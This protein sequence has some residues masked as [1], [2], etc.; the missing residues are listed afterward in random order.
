MKTSNPVIHEVFPTPLLIFY[1]EPPYEMERYALL[2]EQIANTNPHPQSTRNCTQ[3]YDN[4]DELPEFKPLVD[5]IF[6]EFGLILNTFEYIRTGH[7]VNG[8][9]GNVAKND[10]VHLTHPHPNNVFSG[11]IYLRVPEGSGDTVFADPRPGA[12]VIKPDSAVTKITN[13]KI[14]VAADVGKVVVFPSWLHHGVL[15]SNFKNSDD[16]RITLAFNI[17]LEGKISGQHTAKLTMKNT[18]QIAGLPPLK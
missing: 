9:W 7:Y 16:R 4:L 10:H 11:I 13:D 1:I 17:M 12:M 5:L 18:T 6:Q 14:L 2:V 8:M 3:T 15:E